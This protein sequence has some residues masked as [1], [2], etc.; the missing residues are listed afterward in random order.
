L[1]TAAVIGRSFNF[2]LLEAANGTEPDR[3][4]DSLEEAEKAGLISSRL[5]YPEARFKFAHELIRRAVL[6]EISVARRQRLH[7]QIAEGMELLYESSLEEHAEDLAHH[8]WS[9]G[10]TADPIKTIG[11]YEWQAKKQCAARLT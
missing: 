6:D 3:L 9:A 2:G 1:G 7:L 8:F 10:N 11:Y 5:E 4:I